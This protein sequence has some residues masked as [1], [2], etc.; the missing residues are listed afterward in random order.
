MIELREVRTLPHY[1][2]NSGESPYKITFDDSG[3]SIQVTSSASAGLPDARN[4]VKAPDVRALRAMCWNLQDLGGGPSRGIER[5]DEVIERIASIIN[6]CASDII[7]ILEGKATLSEPK[8]PKFLARTISTRKVNAKDFD[9]VRKERDE[10]RKIDYQL[11][12]A[13][14]NARVAALGSEW[15]GRAELDRIAKRL[16]GDYLRVDSENTKQEFYSMFYRRGLFASAPPKVTLFPADKDW[17]KEYRKAAIFTCQLAKPLF[18]TSTIFEFDV[19]AFHAP[20]PSHGEAAAEQVDKLQRLY[21]QQPNARFLIFAADT[22]VDTEAVNEAKREK[23]EDA[24]DMAWLS[25]TNTVGTELRFRAEEV[26]ML[27][28][29][30]GG[31]QRAKLKIVTCKHVTGTAP[32]GSSSPAAD[33]LYIAGRY[34]G[35]GVRV[36]IKGSKGIKEFGKAWRRNNEWLPANSAELQYIPK[37]FNASNGRW[38]YNPD[39]VTDNTP[40][41]EWSAEERK[42]VRFVNLV[43]LDTSS[44]DF[45]KLLRVAEEWSKSSGTPTGRSSLRRVATAAGLTREELIAHSE[46]LNNAAYDKLY[47]TAKPNG[48][49]LLK[50]YHYVFP[51]LEWHLPQAL[52]RQLKTKHLDVAKHAGGVGT[53]W[54]DALNEA[55]RVSDHA[56][57]V[58]DMFFAKERCPVKVLDKAAVKLKGENAEEGMSSG[59]IE[60]GDDYDL[61]VSESDDDDDM[62]ESDDDMPES[63]DDDDDYMPR[64]D[65]DDDLSEPES[66]VDDDLSAPESDDGDFDYGDF[67][68]PKSG[69]KKDQDMSDGK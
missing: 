56:P 21:Y 8:A 3:A 14:F 42:H 67:Y 55:N 2:G 45:F 7:V 63:D 12:L 15:P 62:P 53:T 35:R 25:S 49:I 57:L 44:V 66:D 19:I 28:R 4:S 29:H 68:M 65:V 48:L 61:S 27:D 64:S 34:K 36:T 32:G 58:L 5:P 52:W 11:D 43:A 41:Y 18:G 24:L 20:A 33:R 13:N 69:A 50:D 60:S 22:N 46:S 10:E 17:S 1:F 31:I 38:F 37:E 40:T 59:K 54:Q 51:L 30:R 9:P 47:C 39:G 16:T 6:A 23:A 26:H